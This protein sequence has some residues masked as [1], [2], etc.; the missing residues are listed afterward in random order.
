MQQQADRSRV[1]MAA[2]VISIQEAL[3]AQQPAVSKLV[4][5]LSMLL[6]Y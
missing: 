5:H 2:V 1:H 3:L 4:L 6:S